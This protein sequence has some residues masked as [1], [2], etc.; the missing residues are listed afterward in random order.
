MA[1]ASAS[2]TIND[3]LATP[4]AR[5]FTAVK[6]SPELTVYKDKRKAKYNQWPEITVRA[7]LPSH[8]A[9]LRN[10]ELRIAMPVVDPVTSQ[11]IDT[12]RFRGTFDLPNTMTQA[13]I[14]DLYAYVVNSLQQALFKGAIKDADVVIG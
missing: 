13:E 11:V 2:I 8:N 4:V 12:G 10:A 1:Q 7:T 9:K 5:T 3:G 6:A 14:D